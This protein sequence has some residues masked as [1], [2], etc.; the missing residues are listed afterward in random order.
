MTAAEITR[1][2]Q[3]YP[4][5][6]EHVVDLPYRLCSPS[7]QDPQNI[8][9]WRDD[10]GR[11][12]A[13]A[14]I[15]LQFSTLDWAVAP[16]HSHLKSDLFDWALGRLKQVRA[17]REDDFGFLIGSPHAN[18]SS[19]IAAGFE[20][21][22]WSTRHLSMPLTAQLAQP[23]VP[24]PVRIRPLAGQAEV[25]AYVSLHRAVFETRN[26]SVEWRS[27][28]LAHP[29]YQPALDLVAE[30]TAGK[31]VAFCIGWAAEVKGIKTGQ[32]EPLGVLPEAQGRGVGHAILL[33]ALHRMQALGCA[34][35]RVDAQDMN[36]ASNGLYEAV[37]FVE[38]GHTYQYFRLF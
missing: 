22:G 7:A 2:V 3:I 19:V 15:Q 20:D 5:A 31:L 38:D 34:A 16:G 23:V 25:E 21:D 28:T 4:D 10:A 17:E 27:R 33:S 8:R 18:D 29:A 24:E 32:I 9:I 13:F 37:G 35:A 30:D 11:T 12:I 1:F 14:L 36:A 26:M 6:C